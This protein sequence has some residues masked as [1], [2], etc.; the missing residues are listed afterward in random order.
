[1]LEQ[2]NKINVFIGGQL[3]LDPFLPD[4]ASINL[5]HPR[6]YAHSEVDDDCD[7][8]VADVTHIFALFLG[9]F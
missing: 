6:R 5:M 4:R 9:S 7:V 8:L 2:R 1:M 3:C